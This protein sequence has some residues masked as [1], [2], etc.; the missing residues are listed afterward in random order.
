MSETAIRDQLKT[1]GVVEVHRAMV[2]KERKVIPSNTLF[3]TFN[4]PHIPKE[5][6]VGYLK[7][8]VDL[9]SLIR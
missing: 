7:E 1:Q 5:I 8:K 3:L 9:L 2:K 6:V 4:R